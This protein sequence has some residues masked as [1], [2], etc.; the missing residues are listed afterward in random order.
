M[1]KRN[2]L[3]TEKTECFSVQAFQNPGES[4]WPV[5][6][7]EW[8]GVISREETDA[9]LLEMQ[10]LGVK[11]MYILPLPKGFRPTSVPTMLEPDYLTDAYMEEYQYAID[12]AKELGMVCWLYDEGG[13]PSGGACGKVLLKHPEFAQKRLA[14]RK[15]T[16]KSGDSYRMKEDVL[17]A[18]F[19][20]GEPVADGAVMAIDAEVIEYYIERV[21]PVGTGT[22]GVPD[23]TRKEATDAFIEITHEAYKPYLKSH[24]GD[25]IQA[26]FFDEPAIPLPVAFREEI[27]E[28][29]E[30]ENGYSIRPFLPELLGEKKVTEEGAK[31]RIQWFDLTSRLFCE[32]FLLREK[33]WTNEN[34]M[35]FTGHFGGEDIPAGVMQGTVPILRALRCLDIPGI[36]VIW[37]QIF[38]AESETPFNHDTGV[39]CQNYIFPRYASSAASQIGARRIMTETFGVYGAGLTFDEMRYILTFQAV[40]G[41]NIF[42]LL[43]IPYAREGFLLTGEMPFFTERHACYKDLAPFNQYMERLSYVSSVGKNVS[44]TAI[45]LP[46]RDFFAGEEKDKRAASFEKIAGEMEDAWIPFD[47]FDDDLLEMADEASVNAGEVRVGEACYNTLVIPPCDY[48]PQE[49]IAVLEAFIRGGGRVLQIKDKSLTEIEGA[50]IVEKIGNTILPPLKLCGDVRKVRVGERKAENGTIYLFNNESLSKRCFTVELQEEAC[51]LDLE[52]GKILRPQREENRVKLSLLSGQMVCL[53]VPTANEDAEMP[54]A[55]GEK[56]LVDTPFTFRRTS[57]FIIGEMQ[58]ETKTY[59]EEAKP[60]KLGD[61]SDTV[62]I[63][64][65][66]SGVYRTE[67]TSPAESGKLLLDLGEVH[68]TCETFINGRSLGVRV[69]PPYSYEIESSELKKE[70]ILEIRVTNT[71]ANAYK[72]T[73]SFDKWPRWMLSDYW[74]RQD[75]FHTDSLS[76]GLY[77]P[78]TLQREI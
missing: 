32:N 35:A 30:K 76:G 43:M 14:C 5:Y 1:K 78:I 23:I 4:F 48:M 50:E 10:R 64:Y 63:S 21:F 46:F 38:P 9:Q 59:E 42:N 25:G 58:Y 71:A 40:R 66:G 57:Q 17:G 18:F 41:V 54:C 34:G 73:K 74:S 67:F 33:E 24:F 7:W 51:I 28:Q 65:S 12:R 75:I 20:S 68:Y 37:R 15:F 53:F 26:V 61:W 39:T 29:F 3:Y 31:A 49:S 77:G 19:R 8:N 45:Y 52:N 6:G 56:F 16:V 27:E 44:H 62:G 72:Y 22:I 2:N 69:M 55:F 70:N 60:I 13:W 11:A 36:D 47:V